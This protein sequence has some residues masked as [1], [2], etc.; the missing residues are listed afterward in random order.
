MEF[1]IDII[2]PAALWLWGRVNL[3]KE[4]KYQGYLLKGKGGRCL[5]LIPLPLSCA[6]FSREFGS[7]KLPES[8]GRFKKSK[9]I[10]LPL[11]FLS[12]HVVVQ[13]SKPKI[14]SHVNMKSRPGD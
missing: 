6:D 8:V 13:N 7:L 12:V 3:Q 14:F 4:N 9:E 1:F 2:L 5:W 11:A 10:S